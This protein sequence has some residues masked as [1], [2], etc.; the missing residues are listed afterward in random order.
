MSEEGGNDDGKTDSAIVGQGDEIRH[1]F[2]AGDI[3]L[4]PWSEDGQ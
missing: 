2:L 1:N 4:A 3:V